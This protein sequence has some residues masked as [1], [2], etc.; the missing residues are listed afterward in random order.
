VE[1]AER[2]KYSRGRLRRRC[3][4]TYSHHTFEGSKNRPDETDGEGN[5][6]KK[7]KNPLGCT[8]AEPEVSKFLKKI[9]PLKV[10]G[11]LKINGGGELLEGGGRASFQSNSSFG[12]SHFTSSTSLLIHY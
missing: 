9:P 4:G 10:E 11:R 3:T 12:G 8:L 7:E 1:E 6:Q 5:A 2:E